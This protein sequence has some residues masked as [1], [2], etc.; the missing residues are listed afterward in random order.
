MFRYELF[1]WYSSEHRWVS[2]GLFKTL[3]DAEDFRVEKGVFPWNYK[4][5]RLL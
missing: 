4:L 1:F 5:E 3:E 2:Q